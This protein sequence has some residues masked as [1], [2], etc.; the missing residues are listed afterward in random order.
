M[1]QGTV[2][3]STCAVLAGDALGDRDAFFLRLVREHRTAH[4]VADRPDAGEIGAALVVDGDEAALVELQPDRLGV[5]PGGVRHAPDRH[6]QPVERRASA[7][8]RRRRCR[9][10]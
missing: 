2:L 10:P 7:P 5:E 3:K 9:R 8:C 6:D 1:T 4:D